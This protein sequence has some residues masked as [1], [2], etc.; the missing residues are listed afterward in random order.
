MREAEA[1]KDE[2]ARKEHAMDLFPARLRH[3]RERRRMNRKALGEL[4]GLSKNI[5]GQYE[6]GEKKPS[7]ETLLQLAEIF[8]V[9]VDYLLG[10]RQP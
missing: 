4:C 10:R 2:I 5:I 8:G 3:L 6:A 9:T 1:G 7:V